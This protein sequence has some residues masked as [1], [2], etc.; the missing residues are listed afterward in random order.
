MLSPDGRFVA[1]YSEATNLVAGDT[2]GADDVFLRDRVAGVTL[3]VSVGPGGL[4]ADGDSYDPVLSADG[5][6]VAFYSEATNLV[7]GDT[8]AIDDIF[9]HDLALGTT[10]RVSVDSLGAQGD[11]RSIYPSISADGRLVAFHSWATNLVAGDTNAVSDVFVHDLVNGTTTCA[12]VGSAGTQAIGGGSEFASLSADGSRVA[13]ESQAT[14]LVS[15]DTNQRKDIFVRDLVSG[16]TTRVN[17]TSSGVQSGFGATY[18]AISG[19]GRTVG[20]ETSA[21]GLVPGDTNG[22]ADSFVH[23]LVTGITTR[24]SISTSGEQGNALSLR[25]LPSYNGRFVAFKSQA[26]NLVSDDTNGVQDIF[27]H[28]RLLGTTTRV[29]VDSHGAQGLGWCSTPSI[30]ADGRHVGF[31]SIA[32]NLVPGDTNGVPDAFVSSTYRIRRR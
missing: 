19:D 5:R 29:S 1:F 18:C 24:I 20:F 10:V 8:N 9:V 27:V 31:R 30:S 15:G 6:F 17:V 26:S 12:S 32:P 25:A 2:N 11:A 4:E 13:F 7:A 22:V 28:D 23:D 16:T 14:N 21:P 3:R